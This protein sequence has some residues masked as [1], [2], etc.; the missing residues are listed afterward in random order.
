[1][2]YSL[3]NELQAIIIDSKLN[4]D[5]LGSCLSYAPLCL[6]ERLEAAAPFRNSFFVCMLTHTP[7]QTNTLVVGETTVAN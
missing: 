1:M 4:G 2:W 3:W 6:S 5:R 7:T